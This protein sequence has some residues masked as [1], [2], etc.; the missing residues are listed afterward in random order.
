MEPAQ[1]GVGR[2]IHAGGEMSS[3]STLPAPEL[4]PGGAPIR[5]EP[6]TKPRRPW[7]LAR[8]SMT[9]PISKDIACKS[10]YCSPVNSAALSKC[11]GNRRNP[12]ID[13]ALFQRKEASS[14]LAAAISNLTSSTEWPAHSNEITTK[15]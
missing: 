5:M 2:T 8:L 12:A 11:R 15:S 3:K 9:S 10:Q 4:A 6:G 14:V 7:E 13:P 1:I